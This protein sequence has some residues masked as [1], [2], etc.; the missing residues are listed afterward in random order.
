[1]KTAQSTTGGAS[2]APPGTLPSTGAA[3]TE[4]SGA[5]AP[6]AN[7]LGADAPAANADGA[8]IGKFD[9]LAGR[10]WD[11]QGEFRPLHL[12]N[13][14]R[15][16]FVADRAPLAGA[17]VL[18]V[19]CGGGLLCEALARAGARVTGID[20]APGMIEVAQLHATGQALE[21]DYRVAPAESLLERA[22]GSFD[23][24]TSMEMLEHVP[25]P[26][27]MTATL[28]QLVR[29]A[30]HVFLST[31]N[32][33]LK[34]FLLAI[35][36]GEYLLRLIPRGTHEYERL[37]R[38]SELAQWAR[39]AGLTLREIAGIELNPIDRTVALSRDPSVNYLAHLSRT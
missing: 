5:E 3:A 38:P 32:R 33:N 14:V 25:D 26:R 23:I 24:V 22:A 8:E 9:A 10:F 30:G 19:G 28:A 16:R 39:A 13:P 34:S 15:A 1:M 36:G 17:R 20:L 37:I 31:L 27:Q 4:A 12:L 18:D 21:I 2:G 11:P 6:A 7:A 35:V 29:P